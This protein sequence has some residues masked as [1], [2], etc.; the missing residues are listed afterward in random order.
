MSPIILGLSLIDLA[1]VAGVALVLPAGIGGRPRW[2]ALVAGCVAISCALD[3]GGAPAVSLGLTWPAYG[4]VVVVG[5][6][7]RA[8]PPR[9]WTR[10]VAT[11]VLAAGYALVA[12]SWFILSRMGATPFGIGEPIVALTAVH[13]TYAGV[14]ALV[15]ADAATTAARTTH[16]RRLGLV[17]LALT[18]GAPPVV[19]TGFVTGWGVA[20]VGGAVLLSLGV[21]ATAALELRQAVGPGLR[22]GTR[23]L[24]AT[25][26]LAVWAPMVL[27][28]GWAAAQHLDLPALSI[29]D[30]VR[31]HGSLNALGFVGAGLLAR[32]RIR[33]S[34]APSISDAEDGAAADTST[35][36]AET[37]GAPS[38]RA[39]IRAIVTDGPGLPGAGAASSTSRLAWS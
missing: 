7:R 13:F 21:F 28:V 1:I 29:E 33:R 34:T 39:A 20:Q 18:A 4:L 5:A 10:T 22:P 26:G 30:M 36:S 38:A 8:G 19:A 25:S 9:V 24:L 23:A 32:N 27:A 37:E 35:G 16:A 15:L 31:V 14:G 3:R 17:G 2:W 6:T 12:A 11:T